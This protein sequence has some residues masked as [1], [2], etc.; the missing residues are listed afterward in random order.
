VNAEGLK[1][2]GYTPEQVQNVRRA[3]KTLYRS[4]LTLEEARE[5]LAQM[6]EGADELRL[7]VDF[8]DRAERSI[9]R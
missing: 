5:Q 4:G 9:I 7:L 2:R 8:I 3:Y 6:A 1:G